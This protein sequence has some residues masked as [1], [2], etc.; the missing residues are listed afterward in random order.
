[1][2]AATR[3]H[4]FSA[5]FSWLRRYWWLAILYLVAGLA[6]GLVYFKMHPK[7][8]QAETIFVINPEVFNLGLLRRT[9]DLVLQENSAARAKPLTVEPEIRIARWLYS[10]QFARLVA[11]QLFHEPETDDYYQVRRHLHYYRY[12]NDRFHSFHW[13]AASPET[14]MQQLGAIMAL[15]EQRLRTERR[16][17]IAVQLEANAALLSRVKDSDYRQRLYLQR[18]VLE[19]RAA[20]LKAENFAFI[21]PVSDITASPNP[22]SPQRIHVMLAVVFLWMALGVTVLH[23][24]LLR[25]R[26]SDVQELAP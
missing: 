12:Q 7:W 20:L 3:S 6:L 19:T 10:E 5:Y 8:Y 17:E 24:Y 23:H 13:S 26:P 1:M 9:D 22:V 15:V 18:E 16:Q 25:R 11:E 21:Q 14:A 2:S 4:S